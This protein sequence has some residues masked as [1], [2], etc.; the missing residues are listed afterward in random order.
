MP[1]YRLVLCDV[2]S[3]CRTVRKGGEIDT[4]VERLMASQVTVFAPV[5]LRGWLERAGGL[6]C[7]RLENGTETCTTTPAGLAYLEAN[8][9]VECLRAVV[10]S[11]PQYRELFLHMLNFCLTP[12]DKDQIEETVY[13]HKFLEREKSPYPTAFLGV[14]EDAGAIRWDGQWS[15]TAIGKEL[16]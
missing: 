9:P 15:T 12:R 8:D 10:D 6:S 11:D 7:E 1:A 4:E 5:T 2:L 16:C 14:L 13:D 3:F